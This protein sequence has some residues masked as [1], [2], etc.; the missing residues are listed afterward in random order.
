MSSLSRTWLKVSQK[1]KMFSH[2]QISRMSIVKMGSLQKPICRSN[3][4]FSKVQNEL[5]THIQRVITTSY[6]MTKM[7]KAKTNLKNKRTAWHWSKNSRV[8]QRIET[9]VSDVILST[10]GCLI[11]IR[12][13]G[14]RN[15]KM[16][17]PSTKGSGYTVALNT[18]N[19]P[20]NWSPAGSRPH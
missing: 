8:D 12:N 7:R 10:Y 9:E 6:G 18:Y 13:P 20:Q 17:A 5:F 19:S 14:M 2:S 3:I 16:T 15:G 1:I 4:A 11:F